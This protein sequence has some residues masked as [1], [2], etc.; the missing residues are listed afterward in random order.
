MAGD[1]GNDQGEGFSDHHGQLQLNTH[2]LRRNLGTSKRCTPPV[3]RRHYSVWVECCSWSMSVSQNFLPAPRSGLWLP[4]KVWGQESGMLPDGSRAGMHCE[5]KDCVW[6]CQR[7][8][9]RGKR[10]GAT[11]PGL[12]CYRMPTQ[13]HEAR[14]FIP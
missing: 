11:V 3:N 2:S 8:N 9:T 12:K 13:F 6:Q 1:L 5:G 14:L 4:E 10:M 7:H